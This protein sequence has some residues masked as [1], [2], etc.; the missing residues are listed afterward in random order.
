MGSI[1]ASMVSMLTLQAH[2][3]TRSA[4]RSFGVSG[5]SRSR[6]FLP[7]WTWMD[8]ALAVDISEFQ[9]RSF[10]SPKTGG[11]QQQQDHPIADI[12]CGLDQLLDFLGAEHGGKLLRPA[13]QRQ[14]CTVPVASF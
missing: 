12:R 4:S 3:Y 14:F 2:Q 1:P 10:G 11:V 13:G 8:H 6:E 5:S 9:M 7:S